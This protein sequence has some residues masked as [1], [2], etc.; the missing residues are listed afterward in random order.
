M[1]MGQ[2]VGH[3]AEQ[4]FGGIAVLVNNDGHGC[5]AA[6]EEGEPDAIQEL[7]E[8]DFFAPIRLIRLVLT[9]RLA[10][11]DAWEQVSIRSD[12]AS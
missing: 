1:M 5:R 7:F 4:R 9:G 10:E 11:V 3:V 8:T 6:V 2:R 12:N